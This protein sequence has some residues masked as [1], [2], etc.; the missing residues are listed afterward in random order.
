MWRRS[1][2]RGFTK[3]IFI[4]IDPD[5]GLASRHI[6]LENAASDSLFLTLIRRQVV[7]GEVRLTGVTST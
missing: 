5:V 6:L 7:C 3:E 4:A 2:G 1:S